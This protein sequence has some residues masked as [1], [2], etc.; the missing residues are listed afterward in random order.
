MAPQPAAGRRR[1]GPSS[2]AR[3][4]ASWAAHRTDLRGSLDLFH[5]LLAALLAFA[6]AVPS[7]G[8]AIAPAR[9]PLL[10]AVMFVMSVTLPT[11]RLRA[12]TTNGRALAVAAVVGYLLLPCLAAAGAWLLPVEDP[13]L[14]AGMVVLGSLPTTPMPAP[15]WPTR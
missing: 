9:T 4:A 7:A 1:D 10:V 8:A 13:G 15:P 6:V 2:G 14:L 3:S 5:V 12:A 11:D